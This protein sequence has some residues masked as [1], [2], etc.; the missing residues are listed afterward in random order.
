MYQDACSRPPEGMAL[1]TQVAVAHRRYSVLSVDGGGIRS[2]IP[3]GVLQEIEQRTGGR[4]ADLLDCD[5]R[6]GRSI[7]LR[8]PAQRKRRSAI[9]ANCDDLSIRRKTLC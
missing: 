9:G 6:A 4:T 8:Q 5:R 1:D 2:V 3:E 7:T